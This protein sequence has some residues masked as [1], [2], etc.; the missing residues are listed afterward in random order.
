MAAAVKTKGRA[1]GALCFT[2]VSCLFFL[3]LTLAFE[4]GRSCLILRLF[5]LLETEILGSNGL[6]R[7]GECGCAELGALKRFLAVRV[8]LCFRFFLSL[9]VCSALMRA[10]FQWC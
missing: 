10:R 9:E 4:R 1:V 7:D 3:F 5:A 6:L 2:V 8:P